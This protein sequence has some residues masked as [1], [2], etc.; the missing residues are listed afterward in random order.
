[1]LINLRNA[2]MTGKRLPYDA[3][4]EYISF[5]GNEYIDSCINYETTSR[6]VF[7]FRPEYNP[8]VSSWSQDFFGCCYSDEGN[9]ARCR[10][11]E[12]S[13]AKCDIRIYN[14][15]GQ[16]SINYRNFNTLDLSSGKYVVNG[17]QVTSRYGFGGKQSLNIWIGCCN[18]NGSP[19]RMAPMDF[20]SMTVYDNYGNEAGRFIPVRVGSVGYIYDEISENLLGNGSGYGSITPGNDIG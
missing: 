15:W 12:N 4:V 18:L 3:E 10:R 2:L 14:Y 5:H 6:I 17:N 9:G 1:M 13:N 8:S 20:K 11:Y 19:Y 16:P 7:N